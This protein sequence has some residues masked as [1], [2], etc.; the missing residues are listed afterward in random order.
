MMPGKPEQDKLVPQSLAHKKENE[1]YFANELND[2]SPFFMNYESMHNKVAALQSHNYT[3]VCEADGMFLLCCM[4][5]FVL[6]KYQTAIY[7]IW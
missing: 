7:V 6:C 4:L 2:G 3:F 5:N 1:Y